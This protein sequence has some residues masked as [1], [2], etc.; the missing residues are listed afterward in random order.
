MD[1][2]PNEAVAN[3]ADNAPVET[4]EDIYARLGEEAF[5]VTDEE[6]Q[7]AEAEGD[8]PTDEGAD[9]EPTLEEEADD[10]PPIEPPVS[11]DAETKEKFKGWPRDA[12][13]A[14]TKR[15]GEL[16]KGF[17]SKAQEAAQAKQTAFQEAQQ[18]LAAYD[19]QVAQHL[20]QYAQS[21]TPQKPNPAL[22]GYNPQAYA[23]Q[24]DAYE[25]AQ[26]QQQQLQHQ[27]MQYAQ[28][29]QVRAAQ[30]EQANHAEQHRVIVENFPEYADPTTGPELQRKLTAVAKE[31]G[32]PD[33]LIASARAVD[34]LAMRT[35]ADWKAKADK[36]DALQKDRMAKVRAAKGKPPVTARP[37]VAQTP[38]QSHARNIAQLNEALTSKNR[39]VAGEAFMKLIETKGW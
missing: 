2:Q 11:L 37:G 22:M 1:T 16:E 23:E 8:E 15:V 3:D 17:H 34:I 36:Y 10:L 12:Q 26:A 6:E 18:Q 9:D 24:L 35:A 19:A 33:E 25:S 20:Q 38:G 32:F 14:F 39:D 30:L 7:P 5:G 29:A 31:M 28:Q 13:E 4:A 27:A 21:I